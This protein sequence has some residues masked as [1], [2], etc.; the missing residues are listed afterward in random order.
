MQ[1]TK[2]E[3]RE[4]VLS[5]ELLNLIVELSPFIES[6]MCRVNKELYNKLLP[7]WEKV[8]TQSILLRFLLQSDNQEEL[9]KFLDNDK[10]L[11]SILARILG[12]NEE[13]NSELEMKLLQSVRF[14]ANCILLLKYSHWNVSPKF[15]ANITWKNFDDLFQ[16]VQLVLSD[17]S[18]ATFEKAFYNKI[19]VK[20][21]FLNVILRRAEGELSLDPAIARKQ[22]IQVLQ[23]TVI[24]VEFVKV[25]ELS[26]DTLLSWYHYLNDILNYKELIKVSIKNYGSCEWDLIKSTCKLIMQKL[27]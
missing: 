13:R 19:N 18:L 6:V 25:R 9:R 10:R 1:Q 4:Q 22:F 16:F 21:R 20:E 26:R 14:P 7:D 24:I 15:F 23:M 8:R 3:V 5:N 11:L 27:Y 12:G 2:V 17:D